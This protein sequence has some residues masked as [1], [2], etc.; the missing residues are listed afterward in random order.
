MTTILA[1]SG[2]LRGGSHNRA[3]LRLAAEI[4]P[5]DIEVVFFDGLRD[6]PHYDP[7]IDGVAVPRAAVA[8]REALASADA[9]LVSTPEYNGSV[10]GVLKDAIDWLSRPFRASVLTGKPAAVIGATTGG[11][12]AVWAQQDTRKAL[13]IAGARVIEDNIALGHAHEAFDDDG[14]LLPEE[15]AQD[16]VAVVESLARAAEPVATQ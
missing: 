16:L 9:L 10:P 2:S 1:I 13:G 15:H 6:L 14:K 8:L 3:L 11:Y 5:D 7:D 12:G 4:A